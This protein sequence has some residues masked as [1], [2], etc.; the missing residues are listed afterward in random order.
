MKKTAFEKT[1]DA[2][3]LA[4]LLP[5]AILVEAVKTIKFAVAHWPEPL[6][7]LWVMA[8]HQPGDDLEK[9]M[10]PEDDW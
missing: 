9:A 2:V 4:V 5:A 10:H 7:L 6:D 3:L 8:D 1:V